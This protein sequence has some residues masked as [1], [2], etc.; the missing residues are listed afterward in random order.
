MMRVPFVLAVTIV[1]LVFADL[2]PAS[3]DPFEW[4][5]LGIGGAIAVLIFYFYRKDVRVFTDQ[6]QGQSAALLQVVKENTIAV[7]ANTRT[8]DALHAR[9][10]HDREGDGGR[11]QDRH[12]AP[13]RR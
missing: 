4:V 1:P 6:W 9:L 12:D 3:A 7:T 13:H 2:V 11:E 5:K 10:D 8:I